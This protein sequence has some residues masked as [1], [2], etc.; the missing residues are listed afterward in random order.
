MSPEDIDPYTLYVGNLPPNITVG[1]IKEKFST[2]TKIDVGYAQ[3]MKYSRYAFIKYERVEAACDAFRNSYNSDVNSRTLIVRF[4]RLKSNINMAAEEEREKFVNEF[5]NLS[6]EITDSENIIEEN[7]N[8][9]EISN[10]TSKKSNHNAEQIPSSV[11]EPISLPDATEDAD[12]E[13][14][15]QTTSN[16]LQSRTLSSDDVILV[17][18]KDQIFDVD[19]PYIKTDLDRS[20]NGKNHSENN[21]MGTHVKTEVLET[22]DDAIVEEELIEEDESEDESEIVDGD[23]FIIFS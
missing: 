8:C 4:R 18:G 17:A 1:A 19:A 16:R 2:A 12:V 3:K 13:F 22:D 7:I 15:G 14:I 5:I 6:N 20:E 21:I 11:K 9:T 10:D 23:L